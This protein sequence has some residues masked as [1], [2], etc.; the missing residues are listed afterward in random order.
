MTDTD[1]LASLTQFGVA[2]LIGWMW[3]SERRAAAARDRQLAEAHDRLVESRTAV[4]ALL[5]A[6][7]QNTRALTAIELG[8]R[9]ATDLLERLVTSAN[10]PAVRAEPLH[11]PVP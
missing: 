7:D 4:N 2:G 8:Q 1:L 10:P 6:L 3:L 9:R 11:P 5:S